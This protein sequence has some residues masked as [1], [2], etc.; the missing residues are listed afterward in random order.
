[1]TNHLFIPYIVMYLLFHTA[2]LTVYSYQQRRLKT[3]NISAGGIAFLAVFLTILFGCGYYVLSLFSS[4]VFTIFADILLILSMVYN[5]WMTKKISKSTSMYFIYLTCFLCVLFITLI[6][7][8]LT[9][10]QLDDTNVY[11][12]PFYQ[13]I[14]H[15]GM[16][17]RHFLLN[18]ALFIPVGFLYCKAVNAYE[19]ERI[20]ETLFLGLF[21][22]CIIEITQMTFTLGD[23]DINDIIANAL[24]S[25]IGGALAGAPYIR[26]LCF[27]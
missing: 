5:L 20:W 25:G 4:P 6:G 9:R 1:M 12:I 24:G 22:S 15:I 14:H 7:T 23:P 19:D 27:A 21:F 2:V 17:V 10:M 16:P 11:I 18:I 13:I 3:V 8:G 26:E